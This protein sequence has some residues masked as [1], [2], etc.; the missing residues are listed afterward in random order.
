MG[1]FNLA[2]PN[3]PLLM[4]WLL[5]FYEFSASLKLA[6]VL[7][8]TT[9]VVLAVATFVESTCGTEGVQWYIYQT[10]WFLALLGLLAW[11]IFCAAAIRYPWK[12]HQTGFVITHIGLL[13]L[14]AGAGIQY[15]GALNSQLLIYEK[16]TSK[17]AIDLD[18]GYLVADGLPGTQGEMSFP[19]KL[20][21]FSWR[22]DP[23]SGWW[24][25]L[26]TLL[27]RDDASKPWQHPPVTL[28]DKDNVKIEVVDYLAQSDRLQVPR[29]SLKF[30]NPMVAAMGGPQQ[31]PAIDLIYDHERGFVQESFGMMG[32]IS[33]WRVSQDLFD[34]FTKTIPTRAVDGDGMIVFWWNGEAVDISVGRLLEEQKPVEL[35]EG[36]TVEL[37]SHARNIDL[38]KFM[39]PDPTAR[40]IVEAP[41]R[42]GEVAKPAVELKV[43][44]ASLD[45][46]GK[47]TGTPREF[48]VV[49][50]ASLPFAKYDKDRPEGLGIEY[51]HPDLL[52]SID[53]VESPDH[54]LAYRVWQKKQQRIVASGEIQQ[55]ETVNT[56]STGG[57]D[58]AWKMTLVRFLTDD[59]DVQHLSNRAKTPY[60]VIPLPFDKDEPSA[61][62][63]R[64]V[65][66]RTTWKEGEETKTREQWLRQNLPEP[67]D[68]PRVSQIESIDLPSGKTLL[69]SYRPLET[70][71]GFAIRLDDFE[72]VKD[73]GAGVASNYTSHI[74]VFNGNQDPKPDDVGKKFLI[75]MN[76]PLD[77]P[78]PQGRTLRLFQEGYNG[79]SGG[80][81]AN[82][83]L[84][85]NYDPGRWIKYL[86]SLLVSV[87]IFMMFY[88]KAYFFKPKGKAVA[89]D[90]TSPEP[91]LPPAVDKPAGSLTKAGV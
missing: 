30:A 76:A 62:V 73:A 86:G 29:L 18:H 23:P 39:N 81:P 54:K 69:L 67:W 43:T 82:T 51:Y 11:N 59:G 7:I 40:K 84:R 74:S 50:F 57:E 12:R 88:M 31:Q 58:N 28:F 47:P 83:T 90:Q 9:A 41:L 75:T 1:R 21:P 19:L 71:L 64:T 56:W 70:P 17:T 48:E 80:L 34:T 3:Q 27:G 72:L 77:Y 22:D 61:K 66:V 89:H 13:T 38:Q 37:V 87:G 46:E 45:A 4:R 68:D 8:L 78:D 53:I 35:A 6:V 33:F 16:Q 20:G 65:R 24:R 55:G 26:M 85:V 49:R 42:E 14:L 25:S 32:T 63:T 36:L 79:P 60:K 2:Q 15:E 91:K 5:G 44:A 52:G 10:P